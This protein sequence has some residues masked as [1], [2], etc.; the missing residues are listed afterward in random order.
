MSLRYKLVQSSPVGAASVSADT[1]RYPATLLVIGGPSV[2]AT[3]MP[4]K[5]RPGEVR[6]MLS[7]EV[8]AVNWEFLKTTPTGDMYRFT[9]KI[10]AEP[11]TYS[12]YPAYEGEQ[13]TTTKEIVYTG[14]EL[15]I[16][17]DEQQRIALRPA[18]APQT[19]SRGLPAPPA[20]L[21]GSRLQIPPCRRRQRP[22]AQSRY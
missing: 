16:W 12:G 6:F 13:Q 7:N 9:R 18:P 22:G 21:S 10:P 15:V 17:Q 1:R 14:R 5:A 19:E 2:R 3:T 4:L 11:T 8:A 20:P